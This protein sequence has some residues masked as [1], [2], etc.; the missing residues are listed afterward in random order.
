MGFLLGRSR[1][2]PLLS[3]P[4][5]AFL[6]A[7]SGSGDSSGPTGP[8]GPSGD[9]LQAGQ[10]GYAEVILDSGNLPKPWGK[11]LADL[12]GDGMPDALVGT[13]H[14][15][16]YWYRYPD[17]KKALLIPRH[18]G[19]DLQAAD[20]D[21]DGR[22]DVMTNGDAVAWYRNPGGTLAPSAWRE[23]VLSAE[24]GSH[25]LAVADIDRDGKP[26][27]V[28]RVE[29][30]A[31]MIFF[32]DDP[33]HWETRTLN[34]GSGGTGLAVGDIDGDGRPDVAEN[35][36][37]LRQP[38][39]ARDGVWDRQDFTAWDRTSAVAVRD[40]NGDGKGDIFLAVG[41]GNGN[42][43]WFEAPADPAHG[44]WKEHRIGSA[45]YV[46]RFH[47][48]DADG[49]GD[50]DVI[51]AEQDE[52]VRKRVGIFLDR[53]GKGTDWEY[54]G[55]SDEGSHNI[56]VADIGSDGDLDVLGADWIGDTRP[57]LWIKVE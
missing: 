10:S 43:S 52:T 46:H 41:H 29:N 5:L 12:D 2:P 18:G 26:D 38:E 35:G 44:T 55:L 7:C 13:W 53:T 33:V 11:A 17:W 27:V 23:H 8:A 24:G 20:L 21:G 45:D 57:R 42:L 50:M 48:V 36:Y 32:Q 22:A 19:D 9:S 28:S 30:G 47:V 40:M 34:L 31:T 25:D 1:L 49:D 16:I 15:P 14:G 37:W 39:D 56:A 3:L 51:F 4:T 6:S 54:L